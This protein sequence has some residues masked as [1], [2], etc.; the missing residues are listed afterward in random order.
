[1]MRKPKALAIPFKFR[2]GYP[3]EF[4]SSFINQAEELIK[5]AG[6]DCTLTEAVMY[7]KDA[8]LVSGKY[9][10]N[11]YDF[12]ILIIPTWFEP[13]TLVRAAKNYLQMPVIVWG[14][15]NFT[16][17]GE[18]VNLGST[19]GAGVAKGTLRELGVKHEYLYNSPKTGFDEDLKKRIWRVANVARTISLL[20]EARILTIGY[21]FG[22]MTLGDMDL[23]KM[24]STIGPDL[25]ELDSYTL[26]QKM[27][28]IDVKSEAYKE[29]AD[30]V[31]AKTGGTIENRLEKVTR[32][33]LALKE[34]CREYGADALTLKCHFALSQEY[35]LTA[36]IPLSVIGDEMVASCEADI[37]LTLTQL[38][39]YYL[40]G[41]ETTAYAD[42]HELTGER[43]L[44]GACGYAPSTMC[45]DG[46]IVCQLPPE[47]PVGLGATFKDYITNKNWLKEGRITAARLLKES[48]GSYTFHAAGGKAV[49]DIGKTSE[50]GS[51]QYS[52]TEMILDTDFDNFAQNMGSHHYALCYAELKDEIKLFCK[53]M[54]IKPLVEE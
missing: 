24:R 47:H 18:R 41:G 32:M 42:T 7:D 16:Y 52:F 6:V 10:P 11:A 49:G 39:L 2:E 17:E 31:L 38:I 14:F 8:D 23:T 45:V 19:A 29:A 43:I 22:S 27:E 36:C 25:V 9:N 46:K 5:E 37:P 48:D 3:D 13:G 40:S 1:M 28:S 15:S 33:Y 4:M 20:K 30:K 53:Y 21:Q 12:T 44:W 34:I 35:G 26:I 50:F 51:P 54:G